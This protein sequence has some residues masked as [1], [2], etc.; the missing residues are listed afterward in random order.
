MQRSLVLLAL[1]LAAAPGAPPAHAQSQ[2]ATGVLQMPPRNAAPENKPT[3]SSNPPAPAP[4]GAVQQVAP[5]TVGSSALGHSAPGRP[6]PVVQTPANAHAQKPPA[7]AVPGSTATAVP[8]ST[9][10]AVSGSTATAVPDST[11]TKPSAKPA[12]AAP[13]GAPVTTPKPADPPPTVTER[14]PAPTIGAATNQPLPRWAS[15]RTDEVNLRAGPGTRYPIEWV[16]RR[17]GLPVQIEREFEAWRLVT[18]QDGVKGWVHSA[19]LQGRRGFA[20]KGK[21]RPLRK[22]AAD[23]AAPVALLKPGV[24]GR[25]RTCEANAAWCEVQVADHRGW[26]RRDEIWGVFP[27]EAVK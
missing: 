16:Y 20:V 21:E 24:V 2:P 6:P 5:N 19:T 26:L 17:V 3:P 11:A 23:D 18:D 9:A 12:A 15:F 13:S 1:L 25:I 10:T 8:G 22:S 27:A 7:T 14:A 4:R